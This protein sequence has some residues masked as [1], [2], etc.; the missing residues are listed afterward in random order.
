MLTSENAIILAFHSYLQKQ[1]PRFTYYGLMTFPT[2]G[3]GEREWVANSYQTDII[4]QQEHITSENFPDILKIFNYYFE[5]KQIK[6]YQLGTMPIK[7]DMAKNI[8]YVICI[9]VAVGE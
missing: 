2:E 7:I 6:F 1:E 8:Q 5:N 3:E 4:L 9:R